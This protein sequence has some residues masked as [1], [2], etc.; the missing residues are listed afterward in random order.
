MLNRMKEELEHLAVSILS[1]SAA[2]RPEE[3][4]AMRTVLTCVSLLIV[5]SIG[6][7]ATHARQI[8]KPPVTEIY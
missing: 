3:D 6:N 5:G 1:R 7:A 2:H 8:D 4:Q